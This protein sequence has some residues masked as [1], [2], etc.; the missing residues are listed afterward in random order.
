MDKSRLFDLSSQL[1]STLILFSYT[2][3]PLDAT[4]TQTPLLL[5][6][7]PPLCRSRPL[8]YVPTCSLLPMQGAHERGEGI[9]CHAGQ[10]PDCQ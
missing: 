5:L 1:S 8:S 3:F 2:L 10:R 7:A 9:S 4:H 6:T